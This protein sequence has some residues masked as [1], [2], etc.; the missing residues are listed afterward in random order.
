MQAKGGKVYLVGAG[1]GDAELLTL[2]GAR[3]L[4][5]ADSVVFDHLVDGAVL[6]LVRPTAERIYVGKES[7]R[8][9]LPQEKINELLIQRA[10]S[11]Q[12]V[13]RLKGGDP[14]VFGRGG[15]EILELAVAG[16]PFEV[17]P[18]VTAAC[19]ASAYAGI[20]LTHRGIAR[21]C[22]L[23]TGHLSDGHCE[24]DWSALARPSQ[25]IVVYMG[26]AAIATIS[27]QLIAHGLDPA[28]PAAAIRNATL[29]TQTIVMGSIADLPERIKKS[30]LNPPAIIIVGEVVRL[31]AELGWFSSGEQT[32]PAG[33]VS[34]QT[35]LV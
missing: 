12:C 24:L 32:A 1:P 23:V 2:K 28:T 29:E 16:V 20:P 9:E 27:G 8:H 7:G 21:A 18:G 26:V 14:F 35:R 34:G 25:T 3:L 6:A 11:G 30:N 17:V 31:R 22:T 15:E 33:V 4:A 5:Q 13:V 10:R 19:A